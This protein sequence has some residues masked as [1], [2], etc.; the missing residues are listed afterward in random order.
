MTTSDNEQIKLNVFDLVPVPSGSTIGRSLTD[1]LD[2]AVAAE[3]LGYAGYWVGEHHLAPGRAS[4][5]PAVLIAL[6]AERTTRIVL[7]S[8]ANIVTNTRPLALVEQYGTL[9]EVHPGRIVLGLGRG[10]G[11]REPED[12]AGLAAALDRLRDFDHGADS[13]AP[14]LSRSALSDLTAAIVQ[15][16]VEDE[17]SRLAELL[18]LLNR[19]VATFDGYLAR[20][21][22]GYRSGLLPWIFGNSAG[23]SASLAGR[24]GL[25]FVAN[26]HTFTGAAAGAVA[27]YRERF[28]PSPLLSRPHV[29][30]SVHVLVAETQKEA[31]HLATSY[32]A[33]VKDLFAHMTFGIV[34]EPGTTVEVPEGAPWAA[35][36]HDA[37]AARFIGEP[38]VVAA[39][40]RRFAEELDADELLI[41]T[42]THDPEARLRSYELLAAAWNAVPATI[43]ATAR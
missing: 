7:G 22:P 39:S 8:A 5:A 24:Y 35:A 18:S 14:G 2:L 20:A 30:V 38:D 15:V 28:V 16:G 42:V 40:L 27:A 4:S 26:S 34:P 36:Y 9:A 25:P 21:T 33:T 32:P 19:E 37:L 1:G 11:F 10:G 13:P 6:A 41:N 29:G 23:T 17:Q 43:A 31:E 12:P 3:R